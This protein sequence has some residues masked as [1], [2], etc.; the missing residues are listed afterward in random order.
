MRSWTDE[1]VDELRRLA[2][3]GDEGSLWIMLFEDPHGAPVLATTID[4]AMAHLDEVL[5]RNLAWLLG[6]L[7]A[8]A[9]LLLVPRHEAHPRPSDRILWPELQRRDHGTVELLDLLVVGSSRYWSAQSDT[10]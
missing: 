7:P 4:D 8:K 6:E 10:H 9:A 2:T 1:R 3:P 5:L